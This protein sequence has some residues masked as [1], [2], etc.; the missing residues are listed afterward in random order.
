MGVVNNIL[1]YLSAPFVGARYNKEQN[2]PQYYISPARGLPV[3]P[4]E[5]INVPGDTLF[6]RSNGVYTLLPSRAVSAQTRL[7]NMNYEQPASEWTRNP[8]G[9]PFIVRV[10]GLPRQHIQLTG[11]NNFTAQPEF[12]SPISNLQIQNSETWLN[13]LRAIVLGQSGNTVMQQQQTMFPTIFNGGA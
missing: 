6:N 5:R 3:T 4:M 2:V 13:K 11:V 12:M 7:K 8:E 9:P 10:P 1:G